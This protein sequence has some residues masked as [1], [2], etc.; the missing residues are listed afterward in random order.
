M[1]V[2]SATLS[3]IVWLAYNNYL[4]NFCLKSV[5]RVNRDEQ[6]SFGHS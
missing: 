4:L 3:L 1:C 2:L 5:M 6:L